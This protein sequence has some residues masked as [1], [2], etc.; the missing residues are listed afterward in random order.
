ML[1]AAMAVVL[2]HPQARALADYRNSLEPPAPLHWKRAHWVSLAQLEAVANTCLATARV[3]L[4]VQ[5]HVQHP[6]CHRATQFGLGLMLKISTRIPLRQ[7]NIR[8]LRLGRHL[9]RDRDGDWQL[10]LQGED[11]K[12]GSRGGQV[13]TYDLNL[14]TYCPE[15]IPLLDEWLTVYRPKLPGAEASPYCFLT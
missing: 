6:G 3:P 13:N 2:R 8:E 7:R 10:H 11:L 14:T 9:M 4:L 15:A 12:I 1:V 5:A